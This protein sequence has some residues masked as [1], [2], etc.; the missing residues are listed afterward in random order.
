METEWNDFGTGGD[1]VGAFASV[2]M[3]LAALKAGQML[4]VVDDADRENE[5]DLLMAAEHAT[6]EAINFMAVHGRGLI[7]MPMTGERLDTLALDPMVSKSSDPKETAFTVSVDAVGCTTGISAF[8]RSY[9]I[10]RL[11]AQGARPEDFQRPGHIFP[12]RARAG[13]VLERP[14]HTEAAVD[15]ARLAGLQPA[16][17]I[18][19][20]MSPDGTMAR[21]PELMTFCQQHGLLLLTIAELRGYLQGKVEEEAEA[22]EE[23]KA[24]AEI[25]TNA[26]TE[27]RVERIE[28][29]ACAELPTRHGTFKMLGYQ[30]PGREEHHTVLLMGEPP[31][32]EA[33]YV[34]VH[35]ECLTGDT[36]GSLRC[37]CG[38][39]L[40]LALGHIAR[41]GAGAV[42]YLRQEGRGIG[43]VNKLRAYQ[44]QEQGLDTVEAN[45]ALGLPED[46]RSYTVAAQILEDLGLHRLRLMTN[47][48]DKVAALEA[49]GI[50][51][52]ERVAVTVSPSMH[53][54][55][56]LET[57]RDKMGHLL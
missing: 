15:L 9:T 37:D 23:V 1:V 32:K 44:L 45:L 18:C 10:Q 14:G 48:P 49:A 26:E 43:L 51:V 29:V 54:L 56:Y 5:G 55:A 50:Q 17:V 31:F 42:V 8:E 57:K 24:K 38:E 40:D 36:F 13:G 11:V 46:A 4:V 28:R 19:E 27:V 21:L 16:G 12:L 33:P 25:K 7:C 53:S 34:R 41:V 30:Y 2:E 52:L 47:N 3:A 20:M 35:S 22:K 39:Q 6:P